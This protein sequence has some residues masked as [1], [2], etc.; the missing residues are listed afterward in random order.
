MNDNKMEIFQK[1]IDLEMR[2]FFIKKIKNFK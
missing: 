2:D 1:I